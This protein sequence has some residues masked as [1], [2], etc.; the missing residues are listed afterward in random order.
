MNGR[1]FKGASFG[2]F[3]CGETLP[4]GRMD[5]VLSLGWMAKIDLSVVLE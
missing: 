3:N 2:P 4:G 1:V 5:S